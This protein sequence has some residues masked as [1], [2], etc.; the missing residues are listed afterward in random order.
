MEN[1]F[2]QNHAVPTVHKRIC[3][4]PTVTRQCYNSSL[5]TG[6][7]VAQHFADMWK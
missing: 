5:D 3:G 4:T 2:L 1:K 7:A 6:V